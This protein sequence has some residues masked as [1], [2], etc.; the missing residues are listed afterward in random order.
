MKKK[1]HIALRYIFSL[2]CSLLLITTIWAESIQTKGRLIVLDGTSSAGKSSVARHLKQKLLKQTKTA[3]SYESLDDFNDRKAEQEAKEEEA[4]K[5]QTASKAERSDETERS[6]PEDSDND[7]EKSAS[8]SSSKSSDDDDDDEDSQ[9]DYLQYIKDLSESGKNVIGDTVLRD[10]QD[11]KE[12]KTIIGKGD[13]II[14]AMVYCP[15]AEITR[16]VEA[17]NLSGNKDEER[18]YYQAIAQ[19]PDMFTLTSKPTDQTID[20]INKQEVE[21]MLKPVKKELEEDNKKKR[22]EGKKEDNI[23]QTMKSL[24]TSLM[25]KKGKKYTYIQPKMKHDVV[26]INSRHNGPAAAA[27]KIADYVFARMHKGRSCPLPKKKHK[28]YRR[29]HGEQS[30]VA[31]RH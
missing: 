30:K 14:C 10:E 31:N 20:A 3:F 18:T 13:N 25:P 5:Q 8:A 24:R 22:K 29:K 26:A 28:K 21:A 12:Y 9:A 6:L 23:P 2:F 15:A 4:K 16:R 7:D 19:I 1:R 11:I 17:R 27:Q